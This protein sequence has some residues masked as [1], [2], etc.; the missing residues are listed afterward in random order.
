MA[1][2]FIS[3]SKEDRERV[4]KIAEALESKGLSVFWDRS[5]PT[6][7]TW[8]SHIGKALDDSSCVIVVW[9]RAS[10]ASEW[11][12]EEAEV[13]KNKRNLIPLLLDDI[14]PPFGFGSYQ[15]LDMSKWDGTAD[16]PVFQQLLRDMDRLLSASR[17]NPS[18]GSNM[19]E[20]A[21][22][23]PKPHTEDTIHQFSKE[24]HEGFEEE[25][26]SQPA[27]EHDEPLEEVGHKVDT[28]NLSR[29]DTSPVKDHKS[30]TVRNVFISVGGGIIA[31]LAIYFVPDWPWVTPDSP[32][33]QPAALMPTATLNTEAAELLSGESTTLSWSTTNSTE[34]T[35]EGIGPVEANGSIQVSPSADTTYRLIAKNSNNVVAEDSLNIIVTAITP[36][37]PSL[38]RLNDVW[39]S[40]GLLGT[41]VGGGVRSVTIQEFED[42]YTVAWA[43]AT[44][45]TCRLEANDAGNPAQISNCDRTVNLGGAAVLPLQCRTLAREVVCARFD[46]GIMPAPSIA[47]SLTNSIATSAPSENQPAETMPEG[48]VIINGILWTIED[49]KQD[50]TWNQ[51][52]AYC[53]RLTLGGYSDWQLADIN[54]LE[55]LYDPRV[56]YSPQ[57]ATDSMVHIIAPIQLS[58]VFV[59]SRDG[60]AAGY[61]SGIL[62]TSDGDNRRRSL[63]HSRYLNQRALCMRQ[64]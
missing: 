17:E 36:I 42:A 57:D 26:P 18:A 41:D 6:G 39:L 59:W 25:S 52:S 28:G 47:R 43:T 14:S 55:A 44:G 9:T 8:R 22:F 1:K 33:V 2:L 63:E 58:D 20:N 4:R 11:V 16:S 49:N 54:S 32:P 21:A 12:L 60:I 35:I 45:N 61:S 13:G 64:P 51:A 46:S 53:E 3:Y 7:L 24:S 31:L 48:T 40:G 5:I 37:A 19:S 30:G 56:S 62:F 29:E 38:P 15:A 10:V 50:V 23:D 34:V 27:Q